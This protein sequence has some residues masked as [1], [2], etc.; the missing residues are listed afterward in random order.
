MWLRGEK[1]RS[2]YGQPDIFGNRGELAPLSEGLRRMGG[3]QRSGDGWTDA[4]GVLVHTKSQG[5]RS[6][7]QARARNSFRHHSHLACVF[8]SFRDGASSGCQ[9]YG[10]F[11]S[12][13]LQRM[14]ENRSALC[15]MMQAALN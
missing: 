3:G 9:Q 13:H 6:A 15:E 8:S 10:A 7:A 2:P 12:N 1:R 14:A 11:A 5:R 4:W